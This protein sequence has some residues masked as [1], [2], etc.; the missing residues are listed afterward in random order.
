MSFSGTLR[1]SPSDPPRVPIRDL[2]R[3]AYNLTSKTTKHRLKTFIKLIQA[4]LAQ[5]GERQTEAI[6]PAANF[7]SNERDL[8]A[9]CSIHRGGIFLTCRSARVEFFLGSFV[10]RK[11]DG[12]RGRTEAREGYFFFG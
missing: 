9:L 8:E 10:G 1:K 11:K 5:L 2:P 6:R 3:T 7:G 4:A 12:G